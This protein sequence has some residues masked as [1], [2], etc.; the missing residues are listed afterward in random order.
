MSKEKY[1]C[2]KRTRELQGNLDY[3]LIV[4]GDVIAEREGY[5]D[6][7]GINAIH[8]YLIH[9]FGWLPRDVRSMSY[10]DLQFVL[11]EEMSGWTLPPDARVAGNLP[12]DR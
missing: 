3:Y 8:F 10:D 4:F 11:S 7:D 5:K 9:K 2:L 12:E 1:E 6:M